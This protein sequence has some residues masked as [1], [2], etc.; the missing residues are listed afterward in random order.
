MEVPIRV[1]VRIG[2]YDQFIRPQE[3][4]R[5]QGQDQDRGQGLVVRFNE[6][7]LPVAEGRRV[8][9][10]FES[11]ED[12]ATVYAETSLSQV[13][14]LLDGCDTSVVLFGQHA[15]GKTYTLIGDGYYY[16]HFF[17][18]TSFSFL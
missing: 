9:R 2:P 3:R 17:L 13:D 5:G 1:A 14:C 15:S 16:I 18:S 8:N 11:H 12:T 10:V 4:D 6:Q 7:D